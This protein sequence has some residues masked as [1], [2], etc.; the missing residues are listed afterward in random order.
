MIDEQIMGPAPDTTTALRHQH[1]HVLRTQPTL[2]F[3]KGLDGK[4]M[5]QQASVCIECG[6]VFWN[7]VPLVDESS[8]RDQD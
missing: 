4:K 7:N 6:Y 1:C 3:L 5:L 8:T 2:R